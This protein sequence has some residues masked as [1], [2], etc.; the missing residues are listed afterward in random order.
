MNDVQ[1]DPI[2]PGIGVTSAAGTL[3]Y[4]STYECVNRYECTV[5]LNE[6]VSIPDTYTLRVTVYAPCLKE[7]GYRLHNGCAYCEYATQC[8]DQASNNVVQLLCV[9]CQTLEEALSRKDEVIKMID[10][11]LV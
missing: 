3:V 2:R 10:Q 7:H 4:R 6:Y 1:V 5:D 11:V 8:E 9:S